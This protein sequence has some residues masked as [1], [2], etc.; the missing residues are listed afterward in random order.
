M[1]HSLLLITAIFLSTTFCEAQKVKKPIRKK[2][3]PIN[4]KIEKDSN[5]AG[6]FV[7]PSKVAALPPTNNNDEIFRFVEQEPEF[8]GGNEMLLKYIND[9]LRYPENASDA[10]VEGRVIVEFI[11]HNDGSISDVRVVRGLGYGCD[12]EAMRLFKNMPKWN[13]GKQHGKAVNVI[14]SLPIIFVL[15]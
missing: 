2:V 6:H 5:K 4:K 14:Y 1:K 15:N 13:P 11:V 7:E 9:H 10:L 3:N 12:E 8:I